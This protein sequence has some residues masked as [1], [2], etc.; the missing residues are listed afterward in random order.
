M[1]IVIIIIISQ[2]YIYITVMYTI[3][4]RSI[5]SLTILKLFKISGLQTKMALKQKS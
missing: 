1:K 3:Y 2:S 5:S 4:E